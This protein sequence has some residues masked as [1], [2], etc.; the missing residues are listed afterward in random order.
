MQFR[1]RGLTATGYPVWAVVAA[2][3]NAQHFHIFFPRS[4]GIQSRQSRVLT[5]KT[6]PCKRKNFRS[7]GLI[8]DCMKMIIRKLP[9]RGLTVSG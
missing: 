7:Q 3:Q 9:P 1:L 5:A 6:K 8:Y 4:R 2:R